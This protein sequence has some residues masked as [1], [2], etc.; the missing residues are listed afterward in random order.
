MRNLF[1]I[2]LIISFIFIQNSSLWA[3]EK[4]KVQLVWVKQGEVHGILS[5]VDKG[6]YAE[7]GLEVEV[8]AG[9]PDIRTQAVVNCL[10][11]N[12]F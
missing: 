10:I 4:I 3:L 12:S 8:L 7:E 11:H 1:Q 6:F 2:V 5:A 9:G